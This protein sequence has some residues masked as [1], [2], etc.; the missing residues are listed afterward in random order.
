MTPITYT[1]LAPFGGLG[2]GALGFVRAEAALRGVHARFHL[3]GGHRQRS[4]G[5]RRL[6]VIRAKP[7]P[8]GQEE[9]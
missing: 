3:L 9:S 1:L 2:A 6:R 5:V 8:A 4:R 7:L